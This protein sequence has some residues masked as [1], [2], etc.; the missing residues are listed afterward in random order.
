M[1]IV[2]LVMSGL[3]FGALF[4]LWLLGRLLKNPASRIWLSDRVNW[5]N[6]ELPEGCYQLVRHGKWIARPDDSEDA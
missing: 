4:A 2:A 6:N 5:S 3:L 1:M